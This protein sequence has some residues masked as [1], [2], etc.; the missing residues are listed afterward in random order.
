MG[1]WYKTCGL[2]NLPILSGEDVYVFPILQKN[3]RERC[4]TNSM[5]DPCLI[6]FESKY[7]EY[8]VGEE[9][10]GASL[11]YVINMI[12][13][14]LL[15]VEEGKNKYHDIKVTSEGFTVDVFFN[16][17]H[18]GRLKTK[19]TQIGSGIDFVMV[20]KDFVE[21]L[22][23]NYQMDSYVGS[24]SGNG[25]YGNNYLLYKC[26]DILERV[27]MITEI[28]RCMVD[29]MG[30]F[31]LDGYRISKVLME[32]FPEHTELDK[33]AVSSFCSINDGFLSSRV[34]YDFV[35]S[36]S[37]TDQQINEIV[38][39]AIIGW[40]VDRVMNDVRKVWIPTCHEG[41]QQNDIEPYV[42]FCNTILEVIE[43]EN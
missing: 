42:T 6:P 33:I 8:G 19:F 18:E 28:L 36:D 11:E 20:R 1:C 31:K 17:V 15:E 16:S 35:T 30:I 21:Q 27:P 41:S 25:G 37:I 5:W 4:Y 14:I 32:K 29:E 3:Y 34:I 10:S 13:E 9:S 22:M 7:N 2:S 38:H 23:K 43:K 26:K 12:S 24:S 39:L 40:F